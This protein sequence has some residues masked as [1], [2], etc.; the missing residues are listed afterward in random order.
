MA[1]ATDRHLGNDELVYVAATDP[2]ASAGDPSSTANTAYKVGGL[3]TSFTYQLQSQSTEVRD[4]RGSENKGG[5][6]TRTATLG[7]NTSL[8]GDDAQTILTNA[9]E[10]EN[11]KTQIWLL[12][13][14]GVSGERYRHFK[15]EVVG[16]NDT[17][18][19]DAAATV[20]YT[21]NVV[22]DVTLDF[23]A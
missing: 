12:I 21:L 8:A 2:S 18:P 7:V 17:S 5:S 14:S 1:E 22:G 10:S 4:K 3:Q 9:A 11:P 15:A 19:T 6:N 20:E 23:L 13:T 16:L